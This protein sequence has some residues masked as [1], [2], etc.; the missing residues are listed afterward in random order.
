MLTANRRVAAFAVVLAILAL[1]QGSGVVGQDMNRRTTASGVVAPLSHAAAEAPAESPATAP[2]PGAASAEASVPPTRPNRDYLRRDSLLNRTGENP[3]WE[4]KPPLKRIADPANLEDEKPEALKAAAK[5]KADQD[6]KEQKIKAIKY[7]ATVGCGCPNYKEDVITG[8]LAALSDCDEEVR[9]EAAVAFCKTSENPCK[10]CPSGDCCDPDVMR[11]LDELANGT[12]D[13]GCA[14]EPSPRVRAA[15]RLALNTCVRSRGPLEQQPLP[16]E[17]LTRRVSTT[18]IDAAADQAE[19]GPAGYANAEIDSAGFVYLENV[20]NGYADVE[21]D[22]AEADHRP[23]TRFGTASFQPVQPLTA[24]AQPL[25]APGQPLAPTDAGAGRPPISPGIDRLAMRLE[26]RKSTSVPGEETGSESI[27]ESAPADTGEMLQKADT[28]QTTKVR[29][30]SQVAMEPYIRGYKAG[31]IHTTANGA[32]W[33]PVRSDLDTI[34]SKIDPSLIDNV[35]V[36]PGPYGLRYG[37]GFA[38][39]DILRA[40]TPRYR[41]GPEIHFDTIGAVRTNG[42]QVYG[43]EIIFGGD[44][45]YGY[46]FSYGH[47][48]GSD[49]KSGDGTK[50]PSSYENRDLLGEIGVDV[51]SHQ[52]LD[53]AYQR[54]DQTD[55][56]YPGQFFDID[57]LGTYGFEL[58]YL[59]DDPCRS[60]DAFEIS[61]WYN[62]TKYAGAT[63]RKYLRPDFATIQRV[64]WA[65]DNL[66]AEEV[67]NPSLYPLPG[68]GANETAAITH[69]DTD[70]GLASS[71]LRASVTYGDPDDRL[72]RLGADFRYLAH[73]GITERYQTL[74]DRNRISFDQLSEDIQDQILGLEGGFEK[75]MPHAWMANPGLYAEGSAYVTDVWKAAIGGRIDWVRTT[76]RASDIR[77]DGSLHGREDEFK[78]NDNLLAC[79]LSNDFFLTDSLMLRAS[80][81]HAQRSPTLVERY[82]DAIFLAVIQSGI[83]NVVGEPTLE[84]EKNW[85]FDLGLSLDRDFWRCGGRF[86]NAWVED[87]ITYEDA[88]ISDFTSARQLRFV[89]TG[90]ATLVGFETYAEMDLTRR[91]TGFAIMSYVDG[92]DRDIDRPLPAM[93]PLEST[94]GVRLHDPDGGR[95]WGVELAAR[96]VATQERLAAIRSG[97]SIVDLEERTPGFTV[98]NLKGYWNRTENLS[99]IAGVD[100]LFDRNYQEHLD[101][102]LTGPMGFPNAL[103]VWAPGITPYFGFDWVY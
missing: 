97:S 95:R 53:F 88:V 100:N 51:G 10:T 38:F 67:G 9:Y 63:H 43:R 1:A 31:Q 79:Y 18:R 82:A 49:Y 54:L 92:R 101:L 30:R 89:N 65:L 72:L 8:L 96:M 44:Q 64:N 70:G 84:P 20:P 29:R 90:L 87:Y 68:T 57:S 3:D 46:R 60:W 69:G 98:W 55:T 62:R 47:R 81:G 35:L 85:Q 36:I 45:N 23:A 39:I 22:S 66:F 37:P 80:V 76:A 32:Y 56:E 52:H 86:F 2:P 78:Q 50:I 83:T 91:L 93:S 4:R 17:R 40:P 24:P 19:P 16:V 5:V 14:L 102:R 77:P 75:N 28:V 94:V 27:A 42:G 41:C 33:F 12:D 73:R 103:N 25:T 21:N 71:G 26:E 7:L 58:R 34:V 13:K 61:S 15:A 48:K 99:L 59:D 74:F 6:L 11:K